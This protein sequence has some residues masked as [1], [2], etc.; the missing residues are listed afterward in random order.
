MTQNNLGVALNEQGIRTSGEAGAALL[1]QSVAAYR[2]ALL[3]YTRDQLPQQWAMTQNNLGGAL[4]EQGIR[5]GGEAGAALLSQSVAAYRQALLVYT[6]DQLPQQWAMTQNNLGG[7]LQEQGIRTGGE[8]GAAL[9]SQ[10]VAAYRQALQIWTYEHL[11]PQWATTQSNLAKAYVAMEDW[12]HAATC[13]ANV[14]KVYPNHKPTYEIALELCEKRLLDFEN[15]FQLAIDWF[16][17]NPDDL[18]NKIKLTERY[19]SVGRFKECEQRLKRIFA[20]DDYSILVRISMNA[21]R[22]ANS[23][24]LGIPDTAYKS[25]EELNKLIIG[26]DYVE[27]V[28]WDFFATKHFISTREELALQRE[29]LLKLFAAL[30]LEGRERLLAALQEVRDT[31]RIQ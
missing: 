25:L 23:I 5:T 16:E 7:A 10:S 19:F 8:A 9:L 14:L 17:N 30:E 31:W 4:Q 24:A 2:Q 20:S 1:S 22:I 6:R 18:F 21:V 28:G 27:R 29:W 13:Y 12:F 3:V 26:T 11:A 15:T